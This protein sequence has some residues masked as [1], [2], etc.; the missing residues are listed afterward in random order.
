MRDD[1]NDQTCVRLRKEDFQNLVVDE[2]EEEQNAQDGTQVSG[3]TTGSVV[4]PLLSDSSNYERVCGGMS[5]G[6]M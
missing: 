6:W 5:S 4:S 2:R 3:W 1:K